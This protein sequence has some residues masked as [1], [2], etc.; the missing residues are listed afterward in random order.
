M[1]DKQIFYARL[2][3]KYDSYENW[4]EADPLL[5]EGE[6][7]YS[8][9]T[10]K[11]IDYEGNVVEIPTVIAKVGDGEKTFNKLPFASA[12]AADVYD[13]AKAATPPTYTAEDIDGLEEFISGTVGDTNT[14]YRI[15]PVELAEGETGSKYK[16][17]KREV[18]D[19]AD[20]WTDVEGSEIVIPV[21]ADLTNRVGAIETRLNGDNGAD[22]GKTIREIVADELAE[23]LIP[24]N[25]QESLDSLQEISAWIQ[26]HPN[27]ASAMNA[28]IVELQRFVTLP[29]D[30]TATTL[31]DYI[32]EV[33]AAVDLE[34]YVKEDDISAVAKSGNIND[35][36]QTENDYI[37][38]NCGSATKVMPA[39]T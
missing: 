10:N 5:L 30:V 38:I 1:A 20:V 23:Q 19:K 22:S 11:E 14:T 32:N 17:Q 2:Q 6:V 21:D 34:G 9:I 16:L 8:Y 18:T 26:S 4:I 39:T 25:A 31:V 24:E 36:E 27:D 33:L 3:N 37:I 29:A 15:V 7:V 35:L 13:W 28:A 12:I